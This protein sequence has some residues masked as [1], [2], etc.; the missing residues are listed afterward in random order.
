MTDKLLLASLLK[1]VRKQHKISQKKLAEMLGLDQSVIS[2][3]ER[4]LVYS[5]SDNYLETLAKIFNI[6]KSLLPESRRGKSLPI[7]NTADETVVLHG[8]SDLYNKLQN[9]ILWKSK[10]I[11][12]SEEFEIAKQ[13]LFGSL[14]S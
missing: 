8:Q 14:K 2:R 3:V 13:A 9:L 4:G 5:L 10:G 12:T 6:D 1:M 11:I 7:D